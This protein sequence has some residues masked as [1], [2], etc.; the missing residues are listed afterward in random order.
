LETLFDREDVELEVVRLESDG[1]QLGREEE[2]LETI[3][4]FLRGYF[5]EDLEEYST[6]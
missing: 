4:R 6:R 1:E 3:L 5:C 2:T